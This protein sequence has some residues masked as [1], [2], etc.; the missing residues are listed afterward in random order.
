VHDRAPVCQQK[1]F[2]CFSNRL[3]DTFLL[4]G[5]RFLER[6]R[7]FSSFLGAEARI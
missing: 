2:Q 5:T 3:M 1:C 7:A 4:P 6:L